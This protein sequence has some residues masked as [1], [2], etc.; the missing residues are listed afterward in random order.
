MGGARVV[1]EIVAVGTELLL[2]QIINSNA[3]FLAEA[4]ARLGVDVY[5]QTVVG[6]N[7][8]R[9]AATFRQAV[10]RS[11]LV[12]SS[13]GLGPTEDDLTREAVAEA[14]GLPLEED[15]GAREVVEGYLARS[16]LPMSGEQRRQWALPQGAR[17]LANGVGSAP[18]F[19]L[20]RGGKV[21]ICLPG[22]P[23]ELVPMFNTRVVPYLEALPGRAGVILSRVLHLS[24]IGEA[25]VEE[26]VRDLLSGRTNPTVAP[27]ARPGAV[28]LRVTAKAGDEA[29]ARALIAPVEAALRERLHPWVFGA[30]GETIEGEVGRLLRRRNLTL[31]LAESCT[32][33]LVGHRVTNVPGS[34][35]YF[36]FG[37]VAYA[38]R[39]KEAILGV[40]DETLRRWGA[41]SRQTAVAMAV[42]ARRTGGADLGVATTG[43]AGP[44]GGSPGK[45]VGTV[46]FGLAAPEGAWWRQRV[47]SGDRE[48]IKQWAA[49]ESLTLLRLYLASPE[50]LG[51]VAERANERVTGDG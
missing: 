7:Q 8:R 22:P 25:A 45:P 38:N 17:A 26:R 10:E 15:A 18:G 28:D 6:D 49:Q 50:A 51:L 43:I 39:A 1:G 2:G 13:G 40:P 11:D 20:E 4:L 44:G 29:A 23:A 33:G 47:F 31:A 27:Y 30:D 46:Y 24:G 16:G 3:R 34:S 48:T 42:G 21:V 5:F 35:D 14:L 32:G 9:A 41:V 19:I 12:I 37:A 36:L